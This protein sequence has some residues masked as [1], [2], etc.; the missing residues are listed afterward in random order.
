MNSRATSKRNPAS[1]VPARFSLPTAL[2]VGALLALFLI[3]GLSAIGQKSP[4]YDEPIHLTGGISDWTTHDY[5][6]LP[7]S[8]HLPQRW[9]ALPAWLGGSRFPSLEDPSWRTLHEW[10][11]AE[12]LFFR[13]GNDVDR[14]LVQGRVMTALL[15]VGL[16]LIVY[17]WSR[18]LFGPGAGLFSLALFVFSPTMLAHGFLITSDMATALFFTAAVGAWWLLLKRVSAGT[19]VAAWLAL[20]GLFLSKFSAPTIVPMGA[21]LLVVR[22]CHRAPSLVQLGRTWEVS[23]KGR[24]LA[25]YSAVVAVLVLM[26]AFSIWTAFG[27]RYS[28]L[29]PAIAQP[30]EQVPW[31]DVATGSART[32][33]GIGFAREHRLLPE[34]YLFGFSH[35]LH[36]ASDRNA[37]LN[38]EVRRGGWLAF[39]PYCFATKTPLGLFVLLVSAAGAIGIKLRS[40]HS[41]SAPDSANDNRLALLYEIAPLLVLLAVY[42][43]VALA[44]HLNIGHRHLLPVYPPLFILAGAAVTWITP[45]PQRANPRSTP[46]M[47]AVVAAALAFTAFEAIWT[48]PNYLAYFNLAVGGPGNA[49]RHLVDSSLDWGQDLKGLKSWLDAHPQDATNRERVYLSYFGPTPPELYG[50]EAVRLPSHPDRWQPAVPRPLTGGTYL[51]SATMLQCVAIPYSGLWNQSY[52]QQYEQLRERVES[53]QARSGTQAGLAELM[54]EAPESTWA[55]VFWAYEMLRFSRLASFLR[56]REPD[57]EIG[58][59]ILVYRLTDDDVARAL[60]GPPG[61]MLE[62]PEIEAEDIRRGLKPPAPG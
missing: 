47:S 25:L 32:D 12:L 39:F 6:I 57:D 43:G 9:C 23:G 56:Q 5:R 31:Q 46:V 41:G 1:P 60:D 27:F 49:Y 37:F 15:A 28:L 53:F 45:A 58:Y 50:I 19:L 8:G 62:R 10:D 18:A 40:G 17:A 55:K 36:L 26:V 61:E 30:D 21:A 13:S 29:N 59:S 54:R 16:A 3:L 2:A 24:L 14:L 34:A 22:L 44:S 38:G 33:A 20:S 52:Q 4:A 7:E 42:W 11:F 35:T 51:I 48:W